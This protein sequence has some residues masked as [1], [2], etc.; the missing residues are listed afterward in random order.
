METY[1]RRNAECTELET[2]T[3]MIKYNKLIRDNIP[4]IIEKDNKS[5]VVTVLDDE[6]FLVE[7]KKKLVEE[8]I[9]V[10]T[11]NTRDE[12][13][14]E[15]ADIHEI[16]DKLKDIYTISQEEVDVIQLK[17]ALK[18]GKFERKLYLISVEDKHE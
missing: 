8:S 18:N 3:I 14:N 11:A 9:E 17:K 13:I 5:C 16:V 2:R 15:L 10:T 1:Q 7:L 12:L 6:Q 4:S